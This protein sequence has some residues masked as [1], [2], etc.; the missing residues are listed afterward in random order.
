MFFYNVHGCNIHGKERRDLLFFGLSKKLTFKKLIHQM[1]TVKDEIVTLKD[2]M[3]YPFCP[4]PLPLS[5]LS[6]IVM[7]QEGNCTG[8]NIIN[9]REGFLGKKNI[10]AVLFFKLCYIPIFL[11]YIFSIH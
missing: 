7:G 10:V 6:V 3:S 11:T 5:A 4:L 2:R 8:Q 9:A 1:V